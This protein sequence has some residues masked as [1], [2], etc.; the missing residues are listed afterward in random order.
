MI[1]QVVKKVERTYNELSGGKGGALNVGG[2]DTE[3]YVQ[4]F[5]WGEFFLWGGGM[6]GSEEE[7]TRKNWI[8]V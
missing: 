4:Q 1:D 3:Q 6:A 5:M 8:G 2:V 7:M